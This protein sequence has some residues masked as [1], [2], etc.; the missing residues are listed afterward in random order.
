MFSG[1]DE[2]LWNT[3]PVAI[4][5]GLAGFHAQTNTYDGL[6]NKPT[7]I[8]KG[9]TSVL[10]PR[11][12]RIASG[13]VVSSPGPRN[14]LVCF[15]FFGVSAGGGAII[16]TNDP[17]VGLGS[18]VFAFDAAYRASL[19]EFNVKFRGLTPYFPTVMLQ[20]LY[21]LLLVLFSR[22]SP[23]GRPPWKGYCWPFF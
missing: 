1:G 4:M 17:F 15:A 18:L 22:V 3:H 23:T 19:R 7:N 9:S 21:P 16:G 6:S 5:L 8:Q 10:C 11:N 13:S 20:Q 14:R 12:R 2:Q